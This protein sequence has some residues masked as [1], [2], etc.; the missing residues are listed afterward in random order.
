[1]KKAP[2]FKNLNTWLITKI[3]FVA[4]ICI[5]GQ[6]YSQSIRIQAELTQR[7]GIYYDGEIVFNGFIV[8]LKQGQPDTKHEIQA[9][10]PKGVFTSYHFDSNFKKENYKDTAEIRKLEKLN[11]EFSLKI[12]S[13]VEDTIKTSQELAVFIDN[14]IGGGKK[15]AKLLAK[16]SEN[17]LREKQQQLWEKYNSFLKNIS[18]AKNSLTSYSTKLTVNKQNLV[19]ELNKPQFVPMVKEEYDYVGQ[20]KTGEYIEFY[21]NGN[22]KRKGMFNDNLHNGNW[23]YF[24]ENGNIRAEGE[25]INGN[26][27][28]DSESSVIPRNGREGIWIFYYESGE[29]ERESMYKSGKINGE[30]KLFF[31]NGKIESVNT[32]VNDFAYGAYSLYFENGELKE[33][34]N[35]SNDKIDGIIKQYN[36]SGNL[37]YEINYYQGIK[38]GTER[39]FFPSGKIKNEFQYKNGKQEGISK[40]FYENGNI[41]SEITMRNDKKHGAFKGY[42]ENGKIQYS[43]TIDTTSLAKLSL[44]GE[45]KQY[46]ENGTIKERRFVYKDGRIE[47]TTPKPESKL[48]NAEISKPY[49]C[50]CCKVT[51]NGILDGVDQNGNT[52]NVVLL[53]AF[54]E[55]Y[56]SPETIEAMN[57]GLAWS[58]SGEPPYKTAYDILRR[59]EYKFCTM[60]CSKTC[61]E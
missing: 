43:G 12:K 8:S 46:N 25:F 40:E 27:K 29:K 50:K 4:V 7:D 17:K 44:L 47:D 1:M 59:T 35:F 61:H 30:F 23:V 45:F 51:I 18:N 16:K 9:G 2:T 52:A 33:K 56:S 55:S 19:R 13:L 42:F 15:L 10:K 34:G 14:E 31:K 36:E 20:I 24:Y 32:R 38:N 37:L 53:E 11:E 39:E 28:D 3:F 58:F 5:Q 57:T 54:Y 41:K 22:I 49:K 21:E 60:K 26:G 48:S 6:L